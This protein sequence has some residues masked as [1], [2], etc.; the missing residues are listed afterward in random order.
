MTDILQ[1]K[2]APPAS[3]FLF[4]W[5]LHSSGG[6]IGNPYNTTC[7]IYWGNMRAL[8][9]M[10]LGMCAYP[11]ACKLS[12]LNLSERV[13]IIL[14]VV[15]W[16][17]LVMVVLYMHWTRPHALPGW[18]ACAWVWLVLAMG[19][20]QGAG[21]CSAWNLARFLGKISL[22]LFLSHGFYAY[23]WNEVMP[24]GMP[25]HQR[26]SWYLLASSLSAAIVMYGAWL[27]RRYM[28][29]LYA[30]ARRKSTVK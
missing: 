23:R 28:P 11:A 7:G 8:S 1:K 17:L 24:E 26:V 4:C 12:A 13:K 29:I 6:Y 20:S 18:L 2:I 9:E 16:G 27:I 30:Y 19:I 10:G 21:R 3:C 25:A 14:S 22:P 5:L 15:R